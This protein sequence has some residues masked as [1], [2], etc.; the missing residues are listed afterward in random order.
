MIAFRKTK[1][2][3]KP[4]TASKSRYQKINRINMRKDDNDDG[5]KEGMAYLFIIILVISFLINLCTGNKNKSSHSDWDDD[6]SEWI[7]HS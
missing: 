4:K 2:A 6:P 5:S 3:G 7:R 1:E